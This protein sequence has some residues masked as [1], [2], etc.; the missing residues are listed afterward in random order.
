[1]AVHTTTAESLVEEVFLFGRALRRAVITTDDEDSPLPQAL[2]GVLAI[3]ATEGECRQTDLANRLCVSQSALSR[4]IA[5]LVDLGYIDRTP[6]PDDKRASRVCVSAT[7]QHKLAIIWDY[8]AQ[9]LREMLSDWSETEARTALDS[10]RKLNNTFNED[11]Q[12]LAH[13]KLIAR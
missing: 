10:I 1:M 11:A 13:L 6:D 9:R 8:R 2:T 3:L 12:D 5:D 7:G 4:Q